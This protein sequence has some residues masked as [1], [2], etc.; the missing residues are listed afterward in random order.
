[1]VRVA[2]G[3]C[4]ALNSLCCR[5]ILAQDKA[6]GLTVYFTDDRT[7]VPSA[8]KL[9][10]GPNLKMAD[11]KNRPI[12]KKDLIEILKRKPESNQIVLR[13][14]MT[15]AQETRLSDLRDLLELLETNA[16]KDIVTIV[17][18]QIKRDKEP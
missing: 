4:L 15:R 13:F 12:S 18:I 17:H 11:S 14:M 3:I 6:G 7:S 8:F 16:R 5:D 10:V 9:F 1:M 2:F